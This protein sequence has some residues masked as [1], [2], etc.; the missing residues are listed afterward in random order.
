MY[1][2]TILNAMNK[3]LTQHNNDAITEH[4]VRTVIQI[5]DIE[6]QGNGVDLKPEL[7]CIQ[8]LLGG[9]LDICKR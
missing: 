3:H 8:D 5:H 9:F 6:S 2:H 4:M 1:T 7:D